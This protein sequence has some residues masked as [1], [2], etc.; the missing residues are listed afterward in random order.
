MEQLIAACSEALHLLFS[1]DAAVW[2][3]VFLSLLT[4]LGALLLAAPCAILLAYFIATR[5]FR[6]RSILIWLLQTSLSM[7]TVLVGLLLYLLLSRHGIL[8]GLQWL[9]TAKALVLGQA[10]IG[11]PLMSSF[12]LSGLQACDTRLAETLRSLGANPWQTML[13]VL[14]ESRFAVMAALI[15]G[16]GRVISEVGCAMMVGG[17][18]LGVSR[19]MTTAIALETSKGE[20][21][22]AIAL[23]FVLLFVAL[24]LNACLALLQGQAKQVGSAA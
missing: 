15:H 2:R 13:G 22:Q 5:A 16:F 1:G 9:F 11:F 6:G 20:F 18:I 21:A 24:I 19:T 7:P 3:I 8:G 23:G 12:V 10:L 17:N 4:S 14:R